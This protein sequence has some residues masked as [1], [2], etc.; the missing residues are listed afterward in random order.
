M[1]SDNETDRDFLNFRYVA[2]IAAEMIAQAN[3][4]PLSMGISG[5]WGVGKSSMMKFL[6]Q[7]L[8]GRA[9]D[10]FLFIEFNAWLYQGYDDTRAALMEIITTAI[11]E[12]AKAE[13]NP[14]EG[15]L[16]KA[17]RLAARVNWFRLASMT[18]TTAA[19]LAL[20]LPPVGLIGEGVKAFH[21]LADGKID[22]TDINAT[23]GVADKAAEGAK[24]LIKDKPAAAPPTP[25][26]AIHEFRDD[27]KDTLE[28]LGVTLVVLIDD[29][30]RCL[31][32]TA[33]STLEAMRLFLFMEHTAFIIAADEKM[34]REAVRTHFKDVQLDDELVTN[35]FDKLIQVPIRVPSLGTQDVRAYLMML[36]VENS[37]LDAAKKDDVRA[38]VC[39]QLGE[40]WAGKR[41]DRAFV[42]GKIGQ[43]PADLATQLDL[44]D[45]I[46]PILTTSS[47]IAGNPRLIK[48]F[49]NTLSIRLL[50]AGAQ[51]VTLDEAALAK[52]LLFERCGSEKAYGELLSA[53][54]ESDDGKARL[55]E[56]WETAAAKGQVPKLD[57]EWNT[58]FVREWLTLQP[59]LADMDLRGI[60]YVSR[61]HT[62][63]ITA[64]D[65]LSSE[66]AGLLEGLFALTQPSAPLAVKLKSLPPHEL[67]LIAERLLGRAKSIS[68]WGTPPVLHAL[69]TLAQVPGEHTQLIA[70]FL[71]A[72]PGAQITPAIVPVLSDKLWAR[73]VLV[74]WA[75]ETSVKDPVKKAIA[76]AAKKN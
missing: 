40:T 30:D 43:V 57:G 76:S 63:I 51:S 36:F 56:P 23:K 49:L 71:A 72:I 2:D 38:A 53:I 9:D 68:Q 22:Q 47:K 74:K 59:M 1:W 28:K 42:A 54:N 4:R 52:M 48:R 13:K 62:P 11:L 58:D 6:A 16:E 7:S 18:A 65:R 8:R 33:I 75:G 15:L 31:P 70:R 25:P 37:A 10:K 21:G 24:G 41:V 19:S 60:A 5:S 3:G 45:R 61:E 39:K 26:K 20:G 35:Y 66:G 44:A 14:V 67:G 12:R 29:L 34:I 55:L 73:Q 50:I 46:A 27:L 64:A 69:L 32:A 17:G